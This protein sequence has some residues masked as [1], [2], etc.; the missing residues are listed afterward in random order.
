MERGNLRRILAASLGAAKKVVPQSPSG[1]LNARIGLPAPAGPSAMTTSTLCSASSAMNSC[2]DLSA[3]QMIWT[4]WPSRNAGSRKRRTSDGGR[5]S[6]TPDNQPQRL[7]ARPPLERVDEFATQRE[8]LV[9]VAERDA[10]R[11]GQ[12]QASSPAREQLLTEN[13]LQAVDLPADGGMRQAKLLARADD[14]ALLGHHPEVE[15]VVIV[16]P[17]HRA[18]LRRDVRRRSELLRYCALSRRIGAASPRQNAACGAWPIHVGRGLAKVT[19]QLAQLELGG[20]NAGS[21]PVRYAVGF[22]TGD[23][24]TILGPHVH[25]W[26]AAGAGAAPASAGP[27]V[28]SGGRGAGRRFCAALLARLVV[29]RRPLALRPEAVEIPETL[30]RYCGFHCRFI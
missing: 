14:A 20:R 5:T 21:D 23:D 7:S 28:A 6:A 12:H 22:L 15:E 13:L 30:F 4:G 19:R 16:E 18:K 11:L 26:S 25:V 1:W 2:T 8:D 3:R 24:H 29:T 17:L 27:S 9:G 10:A